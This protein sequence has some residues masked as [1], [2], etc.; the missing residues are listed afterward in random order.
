MT[1]TAFAAAKVNLF[2]HVGPKAADGY[3]PI[4]SLMVFADVGDR[5]SVAAADHISFDVE[6]PF[7]AAL[8]GEADNLVMRAA[9][10][11][12][13]RVRAPTPPFRLVL[14]KNLP[15]AAGLGGGSS[16]AGAALRL[17]ARTLGVQVGPGVL[18]EIAASLG[19]DGSACLNGAPVLASGRGEQLTPSPRLPPLYAVLVNPAVPCHT[20]QVYR[21]YDDDPRDD[22]DPP[23]LPEAFEDSVD[24]VAF[25]AAC[26][27]DLE[28]P[29]RRIAPEVGTVLD[30]LRGEP[31]TLLA[32]V[33]GSGTTCF[34]LCAGDIEAAGLAD[35]IAHLRPD[36]WVEPC[37][38]GGPWPD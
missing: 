18:L 10:A 21:A 27:N 33:S 19:A 11:L 16:D 3:H 38:L 37:R 1:A 22:I 20:G 36:W 34:A 23:A 13:A 17:L 26:R 24:L 9:R 29:A 25:L 31:E 32:R 4:S 30:V 2:L 14:S 5:L 7:A 12:I 35:R 15:V 8:A 6:G 28:A